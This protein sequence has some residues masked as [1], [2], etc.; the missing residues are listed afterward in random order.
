MKEIKRK[1]EE[2]RMRESLDKNASQNEP[3]DLDPPSSI[4]ETIISGHIPFGEL[5]LTPFT[6]SKQH[7]VSHLDTIIFDKIG[8]KS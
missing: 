3:M 4:S 7:I 2:D 8:K 5:G 1:E 6:S